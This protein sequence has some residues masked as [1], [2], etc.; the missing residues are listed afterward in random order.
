VP[1]PGSIPPPNHSSCCHSTIDCMPSVKCK[2]VTAAS[3]PGHTPATQDPRCPIIATRTAVL[4]LLGICS[5]PPARSKAPAVTS[6]VVVKY[7]RRFGTDWELEARC[8]FQVWRA[9]VPRGGTWAV[10]A[11]A[12]ASSCQACSADSGLEDCLGC[13]V[14]DQGKAHAAYEM[15]GRTTR[16]NN[17]GC[18]ARP[19]V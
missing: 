2:C 10:V 3:R 18:E 14:L 6:R 19:Q 9:R 7:K 11:I 1:R 5:A 12:R 15:C 13:Y 4:Y 16:S 8:R 17:N